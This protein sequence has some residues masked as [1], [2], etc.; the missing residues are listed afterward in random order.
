MV[1][2]V[3]KIHMGTHLV[4]AEKIV[5]KRFGRRK[6]ERALLLMMIG[7]GIG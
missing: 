6:G 5:Y 2:V 7:T 4:A 1:E 3:V